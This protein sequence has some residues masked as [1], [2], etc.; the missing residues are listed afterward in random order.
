MGLGLC[1]RRFLAKFVYIY[2]DLTSYFSQAHSHF[3]EN[4]TTNIIDRHPPRGTIIVTSTITLP[5]E[6][7]T[8]NLDD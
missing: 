5:S 4:I 8:T 6:N 3:P 7:L 1:C 2:H